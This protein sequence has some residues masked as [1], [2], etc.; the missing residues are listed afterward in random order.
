M[1][2]KQYVPRKTYLLDKAF[3]YRFLMTIV[4]MQLSVAASI[5]L[6]L[7]F[8]YY[9]F[10]DSDTPLVK[11]DYLFVLIWLILLVVL[12]VL[13]GVWALRFSHRIA[14]PVFQIR[15]FLAQIS[16]GNMP[17]EPLRLRDDDWFRE[18]EEDINQC[19]ERLIEAG[20]F[21]SD[22]E[23]LAADEKESGE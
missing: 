13:M 18:L 10:L 1:S 5:S 11:E 6:L 19:R 21:D 20:L 3:Q 7:S 9:F 16:Q 15:K 17:H 23:S 2:E 14:G 12:S 8:V 22:K 4:V